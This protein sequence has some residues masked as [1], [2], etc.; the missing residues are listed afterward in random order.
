MSTLRIVSWNINGLASLR[1]PFNIHSHHTHAYPAATLA[2]PTPAKPP[3]DFDYDD[4]T[5]PSAYSPPPSTRNASAAPSASPKP[6]RTAAGDGSDG[7]EPTVSPFSPD[8]PPF[9]SSRLV[10]TPCPISG[11]D[12]LLSYFQ[13][14]IVCLQEVKVSRARLDFLAKAAFVAGY[15]SFFSFSRKRQG[16]SGVATYTRTRT[17]CPIAAEEGVTGTLPPILSTLPASSST[18]PLPSSLSSPI[19]HNMAL[20]SSNSP[21]D[22]RDL[23]SEGRCVITDHG[24]FLLFNV[25]VPNSG[26][27]RHD[28]K[29]RFLALLQLRLR[30]LSTAGRR[31]VVVGDLNIAATPLDHCRP[32]RVTLDDGSVVAFEDSPSRVWWRQNVTPDPTHPDP[33]I[34]VDTLRA[35]HPAQRRAYTCW[36]TLTGARA[37]NYGARIDYVLVSQALMGA[38]KDARVLAYVEGSDHCPVQCDVDVGQ[39]EGWRCGETAPAHASQWWAE[40][41]GN[42][43][44]LSAFFVSRGELKEDPEA[45][46][47]AVAPES[48]S[49]TTEDS[50]SAERK[51]ADGERKRA[52]DASSKTSARAATKKRKAGQTGQTGPSLLSY[53]QSPPKPVAPSIAV[54]DV[55]ASSERPPM[56]PS[57]PEVAPAEASP[58]V[59]G[60]SEVGLWEAMPSPSEASPAPSS[61]SSSMPPSPLSPSSERLS[62]KSSD[63]AAS[64]FSR[65]FT[66]AP[67]TMLCDHQ[68]PAKLWTVNKK[69]ANNG[70]S[71]LS[72]SPR[73]RSS[74]VPTCD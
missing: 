45:T 42:Q 27:A 60:E 53:F 54:V 56:P 57:P 5:D 52:L 70:Q 71:P 29:L 38:V 26:E 25:Y 20:L 34:L 6:S 4:S 28:F 47:V 31:F 64:D 21:N 14:D 44:K 3:D 33:S 1:F 41:S 17:A 12:A 46:Q 15:D 67:L 8:F 32:E 36:N 73:V 68:L 69:G 18:S 35:L 9:P 51:R 2:S 72:L 39:L 48:Q 62:P 11:Y 50:V 30:E 59:T 10:L 24:S 65:L 66:G 37:G 22:L 19:G 16:Y 40:F 23:D 7:S 43:K 58:T 61:S 13:A 55:V 49:A 74:V 63:G